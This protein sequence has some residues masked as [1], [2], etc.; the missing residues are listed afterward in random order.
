MN[1]IFVFFATRRNNALKGEIFTNTIKKNKGNLRKIELV[2]Y[3][4]VYIPCVIQ[5][6]YFFS[7]YL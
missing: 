3:A 7:C 5:L 6:H 4:R 1:H 2:M